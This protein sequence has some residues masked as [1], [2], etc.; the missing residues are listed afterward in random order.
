MNADTPSHPD[1]DP[2]ELAVQQRRA[3]IATL[4]ALGKRI[5]YTAYGVALVLFFVGF[6]WHYTPVI[7][8]T[9]IVLMVVGGLILAPAIVFAYGVKAADREDAGLPSSRY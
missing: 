7:T 8:T 2:E 1:V 5:G 3:R 4:A 9:I 6:A